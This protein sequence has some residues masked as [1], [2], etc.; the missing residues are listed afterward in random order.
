MSKYLEGDPSPT[1][2]PRGA[3]HA[4][5]RRQRELEALYRLASRLSSATPLTEALPLA[6]Q[7]VM[8]L[9]GYPTG[10]L[11]ILDPVNGDLRPV[12]VVGAAP[13]LAELLCELL[14]ASDPTGGLSIRQRALVAL[15]DL[16][17][18]PHCGSAW[19]RHGYRSFA[20]APLFS[21]GMLLGCL[22][23]ASPEAVSLDAEARQMLATLANQ[24]GMAV[25][26]AELYNA[27]QRKIEYLSALH[28]CS[29][30]LGPAPDLEHVHRVTTE[31]MAQLLRL[32]RTALL[33]WNPEQGQ[34][35]GVAGFGF[36]PGSSESVHAPLATLPA[37]ARALQE[38]E[39][40]LAESAGD[41]G[42]LPHD[43]CE[44]NG[45]CSALAV[46][47]TSHDQQLGM[48]VGERRGAPLHLTADEMDLAMIFAN[49]A[50]VWLANARLFTR[51]QSA[52][53]A[54]EKS[55]ADFR[56]LLEM[57]PD[58]ILLVDHD[59]CIR[60]VNGEAEKMFGYSREEL[61]GLPIEVLLPER[62]RQ[63]HVGH[64]VRYVQEARSRPMGMG[65]DLYAVRKDGTEFP[66][67]ISLSPTSTSG[68]Q[69]V[70]SVIR[71]ITPR[72]KAEVERQ[73]L[74]ARERQKSE[75]LK[76]AV[77]EAH[78][79]IKNNL[80]AISDLLYLELSSY[81]DPAI[82]DVLRES[83]ERIQS[84]AL[85]HDMLSQDEDVQTVDSRALAERLVPMILQSGGR[86]DAPVELHLRVPTVPLSSKRA[87][88][89]ALILNELVSNA[90]KHAFTGR[91]GTLD[92][93][94]EQADEGL[95]LTVRDNGPGLSPAFDFLTHA[96]VGL[97][98]VRTLAERDLNGKFTLS[99]GP[100]LTAAVW[101]PW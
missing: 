26:N 1:A 61:A 66:V 53:A 18:E 70:I 71:D 58:A 78:H 3:T 88:T 55:E 31:R 63:A 13:E 54:A 30:D 77:R 24:I 67:E 92:V 51:E 99:Q 101:F 73:N 27:A 100:G 40:W 59:G 38:R 97:Q 62:F 14:G 98:V 15:E 44:A 21:R 2:E 7:E 89:V 84:I 80:Q 90:V 49:Q 11:R 76:L 45:V 19:F 35:D 74:L 17:L 12:A 34:L 5:N 10:T 4:G 86:R 8:E 20:S 64:R 96:N 81:E 28:Q 46:P 9:F 79:R 83:V 39:I 50:S 37:A 48:L 43:F 60:L 95:R 41:E 52:R 82:V 57:A 16:G 69:R 22:E 25:G 94:F 91:G 72:M 75:Q 47:L 6:L 36:V 32:E 68:D 87:T 29:R 33:Y 56:D 23:L 65:L 85:V 93:L 42:L